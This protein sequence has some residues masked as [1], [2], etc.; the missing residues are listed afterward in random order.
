M[1][2][3]PEHPAWEAVDPDRPELGD[4]GVAPDRGHHS[5]IG[6]VE[7]PGGAP[8][9]H[10]LDRSRHVA[11]L[12]H[13]HRDEHGQGLAALL[14]VS[15]VA[16]C[17]RLGVAWQ[18]QRGFDSYGR[19]FAGFEAERAGEVVRL[20][21]GGP[22]HRARLD[23]LAVSQLETPADDAFHL[24]PQEHLGAFALEPAEGV[25]AQ[26]RIERA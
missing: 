13:R 2:A 4:A 14:E 18:L 22:D 6:V 26:L 8:A 25:L 24:L 23:L 3:E 16:D 15:H 17:E 1:E 11:S 9:G 5:W 19:G 7:W 21:A 20:D 12:L 10:A